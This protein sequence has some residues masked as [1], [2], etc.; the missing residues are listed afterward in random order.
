MVATV[1][2]NENLR[3]QVFKLEGK[4]LHIIVASH[5]YRHPLWTDMTEIDMTI[6]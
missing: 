3:N 4:H 2:L 6:V 5:L 1:K